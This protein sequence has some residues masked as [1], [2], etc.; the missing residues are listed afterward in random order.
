VFVAEGWTCG[1]EEGGDLVARRSGQ[2]APKP[3]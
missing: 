1:P 3:A 2:G